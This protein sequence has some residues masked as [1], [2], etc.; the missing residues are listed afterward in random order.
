MAR[1]TFRDRFF[2]PSTAR[3]IMS[4]LSIVLAGVGAAGGML[5]GGPVLA[6]IGGA[7][8]YGGKVLAG[9]PKAGKGPTIDP[10]GLSEP[11]RNYVGASLSAQARFR[12]TVESVQPGPLRERLN[13]IASRVDDSVD[14]CWRIGQRGNEI[15]GALRELDPHQVYEELLAAQRGPQT[16]DRARVTKALESQYATIQRLADTSTKTRDQLRALQ[17]RLDELVA[18]AVELKA[19]GAMDAATLESEVDAVVDQ[20]EALR[21]AVEETKAVGGQSQA[22]A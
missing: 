2:S 9:M 3:A 10:F 12:R 17:E 19:T 14:E 1:L 8:L 5:L 18:R 7:L 13:D 4:P 6:V 16:D 15:D 22:T 11:W 20:M 21:Q